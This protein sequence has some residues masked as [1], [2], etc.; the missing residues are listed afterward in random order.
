M[1]R[2]WMVL[3][4]MMVSVSVLAAG[5]SMADD[6]ESPVHKLMEKVGTKSNAIKKAIRT[7]PAYKK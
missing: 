1:L 3:A 2:K 6:D 7:A 4:A 5:L